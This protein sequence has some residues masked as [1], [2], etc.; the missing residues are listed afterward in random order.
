MKKEFNYISIFI[1]FGLFL[2]LPKLALAAP[3]TD[4]DN[5]VATY[6]GTQFPIPQDTI[7]QWQGR[8]VVPQFNR[9]RQKYKPLESYI[10]EYAGLPHATGLNYTGYSYDPAQVYAWVNTLAASINQAPIQPE[11]QIENNTV[12]SFTPPQVG[13]TLDAYQSSIA[14][15]NALENKQSEAELVVAD[16]QPA[17][18]LA[19][20]NSLGINE[21]LGEG[22]SDFSRSPANR[23]HNIKV[24]IKKLQGMMFT[25]GQQFSFNENICPVDQTGGYLPELVILGDKGT[26]PEYGGG[27]CQVSSTLFRSVVN[28]GLPIVQ[29]KNHSYAV[30]YY[31]P[32]GTDATTYCGGI[33]FKFL[34]DTP[35]NILI[36]PYFK[37]AHTLVFDIY[38]TKDGRTIS[39]DKPVQFDRK[40]DGSMKATWKRTVVKDGQVKQDVFQS[41]YLPPAL[42]HKTETP[43][44]A[45]TAADTKPTGQSLLSAPATNQ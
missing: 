5:F 11:L 18:D 27:L 30:Q 12:K 15:L 24:G 13:H 10:A 41:N 42:F 39:V 16:T 32:Q 1:I 38:G 3:V 4:K 28:S 44:V 35:G 36:W 21:L 23:I 40:A 43:P 14:I 37:D 20:T 22:V 6:G 45:P 8:F 26:V 29:R 7:V 19:Q 17:T 31:A 33:D 34:N 25:A 2:I 9:L